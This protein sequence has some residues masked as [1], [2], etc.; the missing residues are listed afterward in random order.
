M[1]ECSTN[2]ILIQ[3]LNNQR[4]LTR[5]KEHS[6]GLIVDSSCS[7]KSPS[8]ETDIEVTDDELEVVEDNTIRDDEPFIVEDCGDS[9]VKGEYEIMSP[10][11]KLL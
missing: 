3:V 6:S 9:L 2:K 4:I 11:S 7:S 1:N 5:Q 8:A 10:F